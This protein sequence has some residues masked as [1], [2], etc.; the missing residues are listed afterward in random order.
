[1]FFD[2]KLKEYTKAEA[3]AEASSKNEILAT[4]NINAK[5]YPK[6]TIE[7]SLE[8]LAHAYADT[9]A[10]FYD[11][12]KFVEFYGVPVAL[13]KKYSMFKYAVKPEQYYCNI[14]FSKIFE[15]F[16][17]NFSFFASK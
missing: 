2:S 4:A 7:P 10:Q 14:T 9:V 17:P 13:A 15:D 6:P 11:S 16:F 3:E 12:A 5:I 1:A 8:A